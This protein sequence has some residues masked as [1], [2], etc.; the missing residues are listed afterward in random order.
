MWTKSVYQKKRNIHTE[1]VEL[2]YLLDSVLPLP[3]LTVSLVGRSGE[4]IAGEKF[5]LKKPKKGRCPGSLVGVRG[6]ADLGSPRPELG[7]EGPRVFLDLVL[8][9]PI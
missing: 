8:S 9:I 5:S 3:G 6:L 7:P 2:Q 1:K 4:H